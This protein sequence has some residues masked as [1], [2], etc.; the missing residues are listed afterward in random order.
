[1]K[2]VK[3]IYGMVLFFPCVLVYFFYLCFSGFA[4]VLNAS[5]RYL[6]KEINRF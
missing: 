5:Y 3:S 6:I 4:D 2:T 1:M